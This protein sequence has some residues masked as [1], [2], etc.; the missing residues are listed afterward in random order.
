[1]IYAFKL[2]HPQAS[3]ESDG[4]GAVSKSKWTVN[5]VEIAQ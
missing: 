3:L 2:S 4:D 5:S 1:M